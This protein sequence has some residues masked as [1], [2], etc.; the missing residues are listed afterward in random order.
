[1][2]EKKG[3]IFQGLLERL[4]FTT[5]P[6]GN[7]PSGKGPIIPGTLPEEVE[8]KISKDHMFYGQE[9]M[10]ATAAARSQAARRA[11]TENMIR[12]AY[13]ENHKAFRAVCVNPA[14]EVF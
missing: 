11:L 8:P 9:N 2:A 3:G 12:Q 4:G 14:D 5:Q 1:M 10:N 6:V 13:D 7:I